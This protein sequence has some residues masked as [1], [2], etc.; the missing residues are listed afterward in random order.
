ML[1]K[2]YLIV[3]VLIVSLLSPKTKCERDKSWEKLQ[4]EHAKQGCIVIFGNEIC[5][6]KKAAKS[7][8][9]NL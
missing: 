1:I 3:M 5:Y 9:D 7:S 8:C 4:K 2:K 6:G